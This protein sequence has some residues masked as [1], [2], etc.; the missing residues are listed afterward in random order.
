MLLISPMSA[1]NELD[2]LWQR[3]LSAPPDEQS[4]AWKLWIDTATAAQ[5]QSA[6]AHFNYASS[7]WK[8]KKLGAAV[9]QLLVASQLR[10]FPWESWFDWELISQIQ[11]ALHSQPSPINDWSLRLSLL[12]ERTLRGWSTTLLFWILIAIIWN[13]FGKKMGGWPSWLSITAISIFVVIGLALECNHRLTS[14]P[15]IL[16]D[17]TGAINV[18]RTSE[19]QEEQKITELPAGLLVISQNNKVDFIEIENPIRG[20]IPREFTIPFPKTTF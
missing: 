19:A 8:E 17:S 7:L 16:G 6:P 20:W 9:E 4:E 2:E 11:Q 3:S 14:L 1:A 12:W 5:I 18:Y 10:N 15:L 13:R